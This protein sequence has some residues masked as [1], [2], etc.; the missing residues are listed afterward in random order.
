M[1]TKERALRVIVTGAEGE[2]GYTLVYGTNEPGIAVLGFSRS[3]MDVN[4]L[5]HCRHVVKRYQPDVVIHCEQALPIHNVALAA[6]EFGTKLVY[7][8]Q[9]EASDAEKEIGP[10]AHR[11]YVVQLDSQLTQSEGLNKELAA[12]LVHLV[13]TDNYGL[14]HLS[15]G[16]ELIWHAFKQ[17]KAW[18]PSVR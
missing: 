14:Y 4:D 9:G 6:N 7:V 11:A 2:L 5:E 10:L 16:G 17:Q 1:T 13:Q 3:G 15:A 12:F 8:I 18:R